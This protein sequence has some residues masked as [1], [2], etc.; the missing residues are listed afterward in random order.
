MNEAA[1]ATTVTTSPPMAYFDWQQAEDYTRLSRSF[2]RRQVVAGSLTV[3]RAGGR[4]IFRR[5]DLD[6][7][8]TRHRVTGRATTGRGVM[9]AAQRIETTDS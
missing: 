6:A 9:P 4:I 1:E 8:L 2:L 3:I 5:D 7:F